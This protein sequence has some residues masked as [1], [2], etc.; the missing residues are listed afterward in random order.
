MIVCICQHAALQTGRQTIRRQLP[1]FPP[2]A[3]SP[4]T[5]TTLQGMVL[6]NPE[7][8]VLPPVRIPE[9][10][11]PHEK[12]GGCTN[13]QMRHAACD[14]IIDIQTSHTSGRLS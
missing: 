14:V 13:D 2:H 7:E 3:L 6:L 11:L 9:D 10:M 8:L 5:P 12:V 4:P 1:A